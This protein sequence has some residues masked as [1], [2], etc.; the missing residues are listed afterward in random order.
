MSCWQ[1]LNYIADG[2]Y[3]DWAADQGAISLAYEVGRNFNSDSNIDEETTRA[4]V[5][6]STIFDVLF[7]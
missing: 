2:V 3:I 6:F 7:P 4:L 5:D 1:S